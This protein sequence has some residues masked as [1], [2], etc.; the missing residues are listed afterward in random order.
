MT[1]SPTWLK[2]LI[3]FCDMYDL[4]LRHIASVLNTPKVIPMIRGKSFEFSVKDK[5]C[6]ILSEEKWAVSNP[7]MNAQ[8]GLHDVDVLIT[9][10]ATSQTFSLEC[11]LSAKG[12]FKCRKGM[13]SARVKCMRSRTLG[14]DAAKARARVTALPVEAYMTHN[15]QYRPGEFDLVVT[16]LGNAFYSTN[17]EGVFFW[18]P[19]SEASGFLKLLGI[20]GHRDA[21]QKM[22]VAR[23]ADLAACSE[24]DVKCSRSK[25]KDSECGFIPNYPE[26]QFDV[27]TG[28]PR[29]PWVPIEAI[30]SLLD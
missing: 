19:N 24:N 14:A 12:T 28:S 8:A 21:F 29:E 3:S 20:Q 4:E 7:Y 15:D 10:K 18:N 6:S 25:C 23:S 11:K 5:L 13:S 30:E 22:Y 26:I 2:D 1:D 17:T 27:T 9:N 16:S